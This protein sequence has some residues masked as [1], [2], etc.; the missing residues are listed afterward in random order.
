MLTEIAPRV[1][2]LHWQ[3]PG[4][5]KEWFNVDVLPLVEATYTANTEEL[6]EPWLEAGCTVWN[7]T[8]YSKLARRSETDMQHFSGNDDQTTTVFIK[9]FQLNAIELHLG[10]ILCAFFCGLVQ[11]S[12]QGPSQLSTTF[13]A[14]NEDAKFEVEFMGKS[15]EWEQF[16]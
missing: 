11:L 13:F 6:M 2:N 15:E 7:P 10:Q 1:Y 16:A 9:G 5:A 3:G 8:F 14:F 4:E 12:S